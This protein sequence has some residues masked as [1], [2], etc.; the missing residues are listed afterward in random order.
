LYILSDENKEFT[1]ITTIDLRSFKTSQ[2]Q[3]DYTGDYGLTPKIIHHNSFVAG[4]IFIQSY[5]LP[6]QINISLSS[7]SDTARKKVYSFG[8]S[9]KIELANSAVKQYGTAVSAS[10]EKDLTGR[11][12]I[13]KIIGNGLTIQA[14]VRDNF[15][16]MQI[17]SS[18]MLAM[19]GGGGST[20]VPGGST[21]TPGGAV[22]MP[23]HYSF[24]GAGS[25][26]Q[27]T[28][29]IFF[30]SIFDATSLGHVPDKE[31]F[32]DHLKSLDDF[33]KDNT[34]HLNEPLFVQHQ[35]V[36]GY[37]NAETLKFELAIF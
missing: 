4:D 27:Y 3:I 19:G 15:L 25:G 1:D 35:I 12:F 5:V 23:G 10:M 13:R 33:I 37:L 36:T 7:L 14:Y 26:Y 34:L 30:F 29:T 8:K 17:G 18:S 20:F 11:Q 31:A 16:Q 32:T 22:S 9:D 21:N 24:S 6:D 2:S 28:K